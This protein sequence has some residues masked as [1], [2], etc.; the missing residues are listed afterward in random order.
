MTGRVQSRGPRYRLLL[1]IAIFVGEVA[2]IRWPAIQVQLGLEDFGMWFLDS[3]AIL[4]ASDTALMGRDPYE[5]GS[6]DASNRLYSYSR[7]WLLIG[8]LGLT[9]ADNFLFGGACVA[10][11][12]VLLLRWWRP[13]SGWQTVWLAALLLS[14]P[15]LLIVNRANNDLVVFVLVLLTCILVRR[16]GVAPLV[17]G[18]ILVALATGLKFYPLVA[19]AAFLAIRPTGRMLPT[20]LG[21]VLLSGAAFLSVWDDFTRAAF[22]SEYP[23]FVFG[24]DVLFRE[25]GWS[26]TVTRIAAIAILTGGAA[27]AAH[28]GWTRGLDDENSESLD[29]RMAFVAAASLLLGC[30]VA[31]VSYSYRWVFALALAPWLWSRATA[32]GRPDPTARI[33]VVLLLVVLWMDGLFCLVGN[34]LMGPFSR[35]DAIVWVR[36]WK[37]VSQP[38]V[39]TLLVLLGGWL[40]DFFI[41]VWRRTASG[42]F[43]SRIPATAAPR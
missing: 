15:M 16:P 13:L 5:D 8:R 9:R 29:S 34:G 3:Y 24:A 40:L 39:W 7:W 22:P 32:S 17:A 30:F 10:A 42:L 25:F 33:G 1:L 12:F 21:A 18:A 38:V 41:S 36:R 6:L 2:V 20:V 23:V 11:F 14:P 37:L 31:R 26:A 27:V 19:V 35:S 43:R 4:A 28:R